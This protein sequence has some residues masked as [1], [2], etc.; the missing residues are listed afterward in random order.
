MMYAAIGGGVLAAALGVGIGIWFVRRRMQRRVTP[1]LQDLWQPAVHTFPPTPEKAYFSPTPEKAHFARKVH[2]EEAPRLV[3]G[4][5]DEQQRGSVP[6]RD[7]YKPERERVPPPR[8]EPLPPRV[9]EQWQ[10]EERR[11]QQEQQYRRKQQQRQQQEQQQQ[12]EQRRQQQPQQ[13]QSVRARAQLAPPRE[14]SRWV[15]KAVFA[16]ED[17][18]PAGPAAAAPGGARLA[19]ADHTPT[20][21]P[22]QEYRRPVRMVRPE[23]AEAARR[24]AEAQERAA[25]GGRQQ[26]GGAKVHP[27]PYGPYAGGG[28]RD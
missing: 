9:E 24:R 12:R 19:W 25:G 3:W 23:S 27:E 14:A 6:Q 18:D 16:F 20:G 1:P 13:Q 28:Y 26:R 17:D 2:P 11:Q 22:R 21:T 8:L 15:Q 4:G 7:E 10:Q 5:A